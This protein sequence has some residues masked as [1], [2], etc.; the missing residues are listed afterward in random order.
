MVLDGKVAVVTG[1]GSG[2]GKAVASEL[3]AQGAAIVRAYRSAE[4]MEHVDDKELIVPTDVTSTESCDNLINMAMETFG[5]VDILV[6]NAGMTRDTLL[7]RM[8]DED[9]DAVLDTNLKGAFRCT[10]SVARIMMKQRSGCIINISSII[11][12]IGNAGQGNYAASKAGLIAFTQSMAKELATRNIRVNAVAPG[13]IE[14]KMTGILPDD[15]KTKMLSM[16]PLARLGK[17]E[18]VAAVVRFLCTEDASYI[19]G[20][21]IRVDGGMVI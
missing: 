9:W 12:Q 11:G 16:I 6:N 7:I 4:K 8:K 19:T 10:R 15:L 21:V 2:I 1:A 14:T 17:P 5:R 18:D 13:F 3:K 20:Q